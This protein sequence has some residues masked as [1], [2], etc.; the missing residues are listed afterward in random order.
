L[1]ARPRCVERPRRDTRGRVNSWKQDVERARE[2]KIT[3]RL[4]ATKDRVGR[5]TEGVEQE[6][7]RHATQSLEEPTKRITLHFEKEKRLVAD[8]I[9]ELETDPQVLS[10]IATRMEVSMGQRY[11]ASASVVLDGP[12]L[13]ISVGGQREGIAQP[14]VN[15]PPLLVQQTNQAAGQCL[16][17]LTPTLRV[18]AHA[19]HDFDLQSV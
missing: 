13:K 15:Q 6:I 4:Q 7:R 12:I 3:E 17:Q 9:R 8:S 14:S 16:D 18:A 2:S 19:A 11:P 10:N 1:V 5:I